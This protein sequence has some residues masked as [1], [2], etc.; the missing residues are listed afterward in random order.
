MP[1]AIVGMGFRGPGDAVNVQKLWSLII[2]GRETWSKI[3]DSR[4]KMESFHH[5]DY[6]RHG[7]VSLPQYMLFR[8][9][10]FCKTI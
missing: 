4:W 1:I 2:E 3:P 8:C 6:A 10:L 5:P 9:E 7:T